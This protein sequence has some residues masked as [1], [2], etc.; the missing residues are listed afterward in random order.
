MDAICTVWAWIEKNPASAIELAFTGVLAW[1]AVAT[2]RLSTRLAR[3]ELDPAITVKL[4]LDL[5]RSWIIHLVVKNEGRGSARNVR[6]S[7]ES[8][9]SITPG[10]PDDKLT[11]MAL[12]RMGLP[13]MGPQQEIRSALGTY[14][15]LSK[16]PMVV[17]A[18][19]GP[20]EPR[21][22]RQ[23]TMRASF[24]LDV[25]QFE[26]ISTIGDTPA[27]ESARALNQM[28]SDLRQIKQGGSSANVPVTVERRYFLTRRIN[29]LLQRWFGIRYLGS[30]DTAWSYFRRE[31]RRSFAAWR[32]RSV[33][34]IR[35]R[36]G[37]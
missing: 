2:M 26:G 35:R 14:M 29:Q 23:R 21:R 37:K 12:F 9:H 7:T 31:V 11:R 5:D 16:E 20:D 15:N 36:F 13:F 34:R 3:A 17:H 32:R 22:W 1:T 6:L 33:M 4:D 18:T 8:D 24:V 28:A 19:Y 25:S 10:H 30:D 27:V